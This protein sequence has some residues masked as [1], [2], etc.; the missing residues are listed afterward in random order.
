MSYRTVRTV[1]SS[2]NMKTK[3]VKIR[4]KPGSLERVRE[5]ATEVKKRSD[6]ALATLCKRNDGGRRATAFLIGDDDGLA[7]FHDGDDGV[8]R[9]QVYAYDFV[10][11]T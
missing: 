4:L 11:V 7:A 6:E 3:C 2:Q 10:H 5:W 1:I 9:T 8:S